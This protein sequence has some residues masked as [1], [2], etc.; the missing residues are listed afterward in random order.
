M[1][2]LVLTAAVAAALAAG[3]AAAPA[4]AAT[5]AAAAAAPGYSS[6]ATTIGA[7]LD[8]PDARAILDKYMPGFSTQPQIEMARP[9]TLTAVQA[10][11]PDMITPEVLAKIDADLA[12]LPAKAK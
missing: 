11:A 6:A 3:W 2:T 8:D 4:R 5:P 9:M 7:L 1:R 10:Y 12:K